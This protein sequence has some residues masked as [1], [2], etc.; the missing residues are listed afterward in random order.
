MKPSEFYFDVSVIDD[1]VICPIDYFKEEGF[2]ADSA[3]QEEFDSVMGSME[4]FSELTD[5]TYESEFS[6]EETR[7]KMLA[8]GFKQNSGF[9]SFLTR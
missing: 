4:G 6:V 2:I 9:S 8:A 3:Y 1:V 7:Q 5:A